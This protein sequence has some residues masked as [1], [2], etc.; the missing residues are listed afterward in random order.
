M[1]SEIKEHIKSLRGK[2]VKLLVDIGRNKMEKY[3]GVIQNAYNNV[4]TFKSKDSL[5]SFSYTDVLI[6]NVIISS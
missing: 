4:W 5:K 3:E 1:L 6:K 2:K